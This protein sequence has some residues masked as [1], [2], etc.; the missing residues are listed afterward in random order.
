MDFEA[1]KTPIDVKLLFQRISSKLVLLRLCPSF[2]K[3]DVYHELYTIKYSLYNISQY[4]VISTKLIK[5]RWNKFWYLKYTQ[6]FA[7]HH[8]MYGAV[9]EG[10]SNAN[11][12]TGST[13]TKSI[14]RYIFTIS[15]R[16]VS[17]KLFKQTCIIRYNEVWLYNFRQDRWRSTTVPKYLGRYFILTK[18]LAPI[19]IN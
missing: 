2:N 4:K 15:R 7:L 16:A 6:K 14:S 12:I 19:W 13:E 1:A 17:W 8:N 11:W 5:W 3:F 18:L 9:I 10:Y